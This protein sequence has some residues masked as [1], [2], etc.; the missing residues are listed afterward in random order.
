MSKVL[1]TIVPVIM[2]LAFITPSETVFPSRG[3]WQEITSGVFM[4]RFEDRSTDAFRITA[5]RFDTSQFDLDLLS[6]GNL[7]STNLTTKEWCRRHN[8][9]AAI[10]A[11]MYAKDYSTHVGYMKQFNY[12]NNGRI[13]RDYKSVLVFN[14]KDSTD[15]RFRMLDMEC[16]NVDSIRNHYQSV[17]Q[18][19]RMISCTG[20]NVWQQQKKKT[21]ICSFAI[22]NDGELMMIFS[23]LP[24]STHN[25]I[26]TCQD[27]PLNIDRMMYLEG[28]PPAG[29]YI[30]KGNTGIELN[31][32]YEHGKEGATFSVSYP[33]PNVIGIRK[34]N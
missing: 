1:K 12:V 4:R 32:L 26:K 34:R 28:G 20:R 30:S 8:L 7:D 2:I 23:E 33:L 16:D 29:M 3:K 19:I 21:S 6:A 17:I 24:M 22:N 13:R 25:F 14:P 11:G 27:L 15:P 18:N 5:F 31:G 9:V 10:N